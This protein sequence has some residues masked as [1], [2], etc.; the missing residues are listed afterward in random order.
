MSVSQMEC[1]KF[2]LKGFIWPPGLQQ[3]MELQLIIVIPKDGHWMLL[4]VS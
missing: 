3:E 4:R 2:V 1:Q